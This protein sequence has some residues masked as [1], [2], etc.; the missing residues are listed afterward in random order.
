MGK[1][2]LTTLLSKD[3]DSFYLFIRKGKQIGFTDDRIKV[4]EIGDFSSEQQ[5]KTAF[6]SI[7]ADKETIFY[8]FSSIGGYTGGKPLWEYS[9][10]EL[11]SMLKLNLFT[12]FLVCKYFSLLVKDSAAGSICLTSAMTSVRPESNKSVYG[13]SKSALN[14]MVKTLALEGR[15]INLSANAIAPYIIDTPEN[16][17]WI[18][19]T[20]ILITPEEIGDLIHSL[21]ESF[22]YVSGNIVEIKQ[23]L[24]FSN[25]NK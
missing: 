10:E 15:D 23:K 6:E 17:E 7:K 19:D 16:R 5:V 4:I 20:S 8:L 2:V 3:Y 22:R 12:S 9:A 25:V 13:L 1:G 18:K 21:F 14:S 24:S 11:D